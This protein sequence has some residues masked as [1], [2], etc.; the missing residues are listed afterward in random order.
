M[1]SF[2]RSMPEEINRIVT[3]HLSSI[4]FTTEPS[5]NGNL[6]KEGISSSQIHKKLLLDTPSLLGGGKEQAPG[7]G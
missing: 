5:E 1:R 7:A 3:D 4:L 2:D 6:L